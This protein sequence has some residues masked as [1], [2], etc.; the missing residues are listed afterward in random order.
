[1]NGNLRLRPG[2]K[3]D[4]ETLVALDRIA[5]AGSA[6]RRSEIETATSAG[7]LYVAERGSELLGYVIVLDGFLGC[8]F[9]DLLYVGANFRR[10]GVGRA[11]LEHA[12]S[13]SPSAA[14]LTSTNSSN[15]PMQQ[16]LLRSGWTPCGILSGLDVDDPEVFFRLRRPGKVDRP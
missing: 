11:L 10:E 9:L 3:R 14:V 5:A 13:T 15:L 7:R 4:L 16:L 8:R 2:T 12:V 6:D 1:M